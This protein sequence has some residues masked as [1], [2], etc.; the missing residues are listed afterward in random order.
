MTPLGGETVGGS[1]VAA[2]PPEHILAV[3]VVTVVAAAGVVRD[4]RLWVAVR[5]VVDK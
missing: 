5:Q 3:F 4:R 1:C 2:P